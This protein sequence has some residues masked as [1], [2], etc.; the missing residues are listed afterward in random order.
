MGTSVSPCRGVGAAVDVFPIRQPAVPLLAGA[1]VHQG[2]TLVHFR[3]QLE[4]LQDTS[5]MLELNLSIF[6][7]HPRVKLG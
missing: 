2:L 7:P 5:L 6:G 1:P 4:V 3:A